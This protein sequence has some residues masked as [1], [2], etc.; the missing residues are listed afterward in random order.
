MSERK[1]GV[2]EAHYDCADCDSYLVEALANQR[3]KLCAEYDDLDARFKSAQRHGQ[4]RHV[5][6]K[7]T[8]IIAM[9]ASISSI[10][11]VKRSRK[12]NFLAKKLRRATKYGTAI[13]QV[14]W[15]TKEE[16]P[17]AKKVN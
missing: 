11:G 7:I 3:R 16:W 8:E 14:S 5:A 17:S 15:T 4:S 10:K 12:P 2:C 6:A 13:W 9:R 1:I